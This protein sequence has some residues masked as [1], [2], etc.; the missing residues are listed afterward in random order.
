MKV[1]T[2]S[3]FQIIYSLFEHEYLGYLFESFV[4]Q[5]DDKNRLTYLNQ[6]ISS[7]NAF[8]F[9]AGLDERDYELIKL[10]DSMQQIAVIKFFYKKAIKPN[11][12]FLKIYNKEKGNAVLQEE[13]HKYLEKRRC[14]I[15]NLLHGKMLY[16]MGN[17]GEPA[18]K[19]IEVMP[20]K[21]NVLFHFRRNEDNTHYF[22]TI[23]YQGEKLNFQY[24]G[25]YII[26]HQPAWMVLD[27]KLYNFNKEVDGHKLTPFLNKKFIVIPHK[28][29]ETYYKKFVAPLVASFDVYAKGFEINSERHSPIPLLTFS[30]LATSN[31]NGTLSLF[32]NSDGGSFATHQEEEGNILFDLSFQYG[33]HNFRADHMSPTSVSV[34]KTGE[35]YVFHKVK[36]E[37][38][39][40]KKIIALLREIGLDL[41]SARF[42]FPKSKA[43][44]WL[45]NYKSI[46]E[47]EGFIL[48]QNFNDTK[49][50]FLGE[51][52]ILVEV[53]ENIDW[54]DVFAV[55]KFGEYEIPFSK[56]RK[57]IVKKQREILLPNGEIAV[58]P[59]V[60]FSEYA[61]LFAFVEEGKGRSHS[62]QLKKHHLSL[63]QD[64]ESG[65]LAKV[66]MDRK[67]QRL[68][69]FDRIEDYPLPL[70]FKGELRPY[71]KAGYNW[72]NFLQKY[73]FGG[74]LA[75]D[76]GLGKTVQTLAMLQAQKEE[77]N[78]SASL[79]IM[80][81]SLIYNWEMEA[82][83]FTP[84]LKVLNYTGTSRTKEANVFSDYDLVLTSYGITRLD[85]EILKNY[86]FH[87]IILDESQ[88]IKNPLSNIAKSVKKLNSRFRLILTGTP[89][90]NSTLDLWSQ[91]TFINPGLLGNHTFFK[92]E[93]LNPIEK[94]NDL[95]KTVK[96]N[97]IIKPFILR[98]HKS[99]VATELPP[100]IEHI[101]YCRMT[102]LQEEKYEEVKSFYRNKIL[103]SIESRGVNNSH[104]LLLQGLVK[105][106]QLANHPKMVDPTYSGDSGKLEDIKHMLISAIGK[107]HKI[108]IFSQFV[109]HL[110]IL[111]EYLKCQ[112]LDYAYLDGTTKDRKSAVERFQNDEDLKIFLISLKAGGLG[113]NLTKADYVFLL[114]PWWNP[115]AEAQ[116]VDRAHRIG[117]EN[118]VFT[119]KFITKNTVEEK[120]LALQKNKIRLAS[121]LIT[122]EES[123][124]KNLSKDDIASLLE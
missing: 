72:M 88:A 85:I 116:A 92:N 25:A 4:V 106:R 71:Q 100:K 14:K 66:T 19:R 82:K 83:K 45:N 17:D 56:I 61:E 46:L 50:Y 15:L 24:K 41:R 67:L 89:L 65:E 47:K 38:A 8:E 16:E 62:L 74:C 44:S 30:E 104:M 64:L 28:V 5:L 124:V 51:S 69:E 55:I 20:E 115:A 59:E 78:K 91:M 52:S 90:E 36:R 1:S 103:E 93:F 32:D 6:N 21:A 26:C 43:F 111:S 79:L 10:M 105:L 39:D 108:L 73:K 121:D 12:F 102:A 70:N 40:E 94:K 18:W 87:Y 60:W 49:K 42:T 114:D 53:R 77:G 54:F 118:K 9:S 2:A 29:E 84:E 80:P 109:K 117:Q 7:K 3:P 81:T 23:K 123:F 97:S 96:L 107:D 58:I 99:Q 34:E 22:P 98:R 13:I 95:N 37:L 35:S 119:Y 27:S 110:S 31:G 120:I 68:R 75:D 101:Q 57:L 113:L 63:V 76:M 86:Y 122:T 11:D 112:R 33:N 48:K